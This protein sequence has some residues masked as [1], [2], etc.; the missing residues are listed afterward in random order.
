MP[1]GGRLARQSSAAYDPAHG[2]PQESRVKLTIGLTYDL[3]SEYLSLGYPQETIAE[4]DEDVTING[5]EQAIRELG[6]QTDRIGHIRTLARR[7][8]AGDRWDLVF[9]IAEGLKGRSREAQVPALLEAYDVPCTFSDPLVCAVT[10]DKAVAKRV[11][12]SSGL[13]TPGFHVVHQEAEVDRVALPYP[14]FAKPIAEGTGKGIDRVSCVKT[15]DELR[16]VC[17]TLLARFN[18]PV[19]VEEFL[20][21]REFTV[22]I[23]GTGSQARILGSMEVVMRPNAATTIYSYEM[24]EKCDDYVDYLRPE[25]NALTSAVETLALESYRA[26]EVRDAGRVDIR[27]DRDG[28]PSF[29]EV[30][31]LPGLNPGHSD[32]PM[33]ARREGMNF[34]DLIGAIIASALKRVGAL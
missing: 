4:F 15:P 21:G 13:R 18:Q 3:R 24:K 20:P 34:R 19:L 25:R 30:N 17:L 28:N 1:R 5:L 23:L 2:M 9:N 16:Q 29:M 6:Y 8:V 32:L 12:Q 33:I 22:A 11:L 26:L 14:L 31:P 27:L 7:L 10:L